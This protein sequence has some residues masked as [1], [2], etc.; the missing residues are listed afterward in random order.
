MESIWSKTTKIQ[1]RPALSSDLSVE[2]AVIGGGM[3]GILIA[4]FLQQKG[5]KVIVLEADRIGGGQTRNTT[6][7]ITS[8]HGLTYEKLIRKYGTEKAGLYAR[9]NEEAI[10]KYQDIIEENNI[11]CDFERLP[12]Y[13]Y[14]TRERHKL[15]REAEAAAELGLPATYVET[16]PL[17][18][19]TVGAVCFENQA[20]FH[21]LK[22]LKE[23]S[24]KLEIFEKTMVY[25][26]KGHKIV[27][28]WGT[29]NAENIVFATHY[30]FPLVPGCYFLRQHQERSYI[31]AFSGIKK[32]D[33]MYY[34]IDKA[35]LSIRSAGDW[36][37]LGGGA[38]RTGENESGGSYASIR[39]QAKKY[40][41][42]GKEVAHWSAQDCKTHDQLPLI[43]SYSRFRPYWYVAT[44]FEKWGMTFSMISA[45][46]I[47]DRI[48]GTENPYQ[49][50]FSPQR[51]H[52]LISACDLM[53]DVGISVRG[54]LTGYHVWTCMKEKDLEN[55][56]G[57][58]VRKG[59]RRY[60][61]YRDE[62]GNIHRISIRCPHMGCELLWN[63]DELSW[64][65]P[66]HGSRF[67]CD[68]N[69][70]DNPAQK[71]KKEILD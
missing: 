69:L 62:A 33:G 22:F 41:P 14:S 25:S 53:I 71:D 3:A 55:G 9:A 13:L 66:C 40:M 31:V 10:Q 56:H 68:G 57:G 2:T 61:S 26:V 11:D 12:S 7:K 67:D 16:V 19:S 52:P 45:M 21:P 39:A 27:T 60:A 51:F 1:E 63:P 18:F 49:K 65:C 43:G 64:D 59:F 8:Q 46:I 54:L 50:L 48:C 24:K 58:I 29:V 32:L 37:L 4:F 38:H 44:G 34:S 35:G 28:N 20:Q 47:S 70:I 15:E 42:Q 36:T 17:P 5:R 6:A 30:P 23:I